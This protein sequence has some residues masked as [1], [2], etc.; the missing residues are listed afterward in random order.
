MRRLVVLLA[1]AV[2]VCLV[3]RPASSQV[4]LPSQFDMLQWMAP[5]QG[6]QNGAFYVVQPMSGTF[7]W[8]KSANGY[9]WDVDLFDGAYIYQSI[10]EQ[11]WNQPTTFKRF[12]QPLRWMPRCV[13]MPTT[14]GKI[15]SIT[16]NSSDTDFEIHS[17]CTS[18]T[19]SN[20]GNVV[21]ELW[22]PYQRQIGM[23]PAAPTITLSYRYS[24]DSSFS[25]CKYKE[26]FDLQ[27]GTGLVRWTLYQLQSGVYW[28][29]N[30]TVHGAATAGAVMPVHPC[31]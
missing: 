3:S 13:D 5:S 14:P 15:A 19:V 10:T 22:G 2:A 25:S 8:V 7:Y 17:S 26:T 18:Y 23:Q 12:V 11:V 4:C 31:W 28:Q 21:N 6:L 1:I 30:Q 24:C 16:V 9:P 29:Q 27:Q 20:L